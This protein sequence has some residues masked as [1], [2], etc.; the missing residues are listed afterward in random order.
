[1]DKLIR[2]KLVGFRASPKITAARTF[3]ARTDAVIPIITVSKAATRIA[4]DGCLDLAQMIDEFP[5]D[6]VYVGH[7][8]IRTNPDAVIDDAP[9]VFGEMTVNFRGNGSQGFIEQ[10]FNPRIR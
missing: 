1:M 6:S 7:L 3:V 10:N 2:A 4:N 8:G 5:A 9:E